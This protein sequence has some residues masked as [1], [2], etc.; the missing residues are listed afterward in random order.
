MTD[1]KSPSAFERLQL[2]LM[3][4]LI[5]IV[6]FGIIA[7]LITRPRPVPITVI[8][9]E[10]TGTSPPPTA[11][12]TPGPIT[13]YVTGAVNKPGVYALRWDSIVQN[14]LEAAGGAL[15]DADLDRINL[16][17]ALRDNMQIHAPFKGTPAP[18]LAT[19]G[20]HNIVYINRAADPAELEALPGIGPAL[21]EAILAYRS[22]IGGRFAGVDQLLE[23][24]GIG[25]AK[26]DGM[27]EFISLE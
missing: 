16:A 27:R 23:V 4:I 14:A 8:P 25:P 6:T 15:P 5:I 13:V 24:P 10:P 22:K 19:P 21:A 3:L 12:P 7:L 2:L 18:D 20:D 9:P 1:Q 11:S 17:D 26:L